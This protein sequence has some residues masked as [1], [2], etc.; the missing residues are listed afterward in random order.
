M[1]FHCPDTHVC[2]HGKRGWGAA[3]D[4]LRPGEAVWESGQASPHGFSM[5]TGTVVANSTSGQR[6]FFHNGRAWQWDWAYS[7]SCVAWRAACPPSPPLCMASLWKSSQRSSLCGTKLTGAIFVWD[8]D[9]VAA[10]RRVKESERQSHGLDPSAP[11][12]L[13]SK[14]Y[15]IIMTFIV[16]HKVNLL[17]H[18]FFYGWSLKDVASQ[19]AWQNSPLSSACVPASTVETPI[20]SPMSCVHLLLGLPLPLLPS[21]V[22]SKNSF[23]NVLCRLMWPK[24]DS[25]CFLIR[26]KSCGAFMLSC[27]RTLAFVF[28]LV[29][30]S[31]LYISN[32]H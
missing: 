4:G 8:E 3:E 11:V 32:Y 27:S 31:T 14:V 12:D 29:F 23:S 19:T 20:H 13:T 18:F 9:E 16:K 25:F 15:K 26:F 2:P 30:L 17:R 5:S 10:L 6:I 22:P 1:L 21:H 28:L 24:Y 7:T